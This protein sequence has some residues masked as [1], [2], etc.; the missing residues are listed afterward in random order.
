[1]SFCLIILS[2]STNTMQ[3]YVTLIQIFYIK[4]QDFCN[5]VAN[6]V[7]KRFDKSNYEIDRPLQLGKSKK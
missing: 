2:Q 1:M 7:E 6:D 3:K 4:T 5:D